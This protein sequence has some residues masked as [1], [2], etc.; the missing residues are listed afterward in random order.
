[1]NKE[2]NIINKF[3]S[4]SKAAETLGLN[5]QLIRY[6]ADK[7]KLW[8][9]KYLFK[10]IPKLPLDESF[11]NSSVKISSVEVLDSEG[12]LIHK[13]DSIT[14]AAETLGLSRSTTP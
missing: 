7:G 10:L 11:I 14:K 5:R 9:D 4:I 2:G 8:K 13:F 1:M 6:N 3:D 12:N